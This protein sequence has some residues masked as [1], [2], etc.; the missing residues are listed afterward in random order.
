MDTGRCKLCLQKRPLL[1][2]SHIIPEFMYRDLF[3]EHHKMY[4][5]APSSYVEGDRK[6]MRPSSGEYDSDILCAECDNERLGRLESYAQQ[7]MYGGQLPEQERPMVKNVKTPEGVVFSHATNLSYQKFK[8]FLLSILWRA[9]VSRRDFFK[10]VSLGPYEEIIRNM[11]MEDDPKTEDVFPIIMLTW[12]NDKSTPK[13]LVGQPGKNRAEKGIRY[14]FIIGGITYVFYVSPGWLPDR[15]KPFT[16]QPS[17]EAF[18]L[19]IP[20]GKSWELW[21]TYFNVK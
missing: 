6:V 9:S 18:L 13:D 2:K 12:L 11:L 14:V 3:D 17:N 10:E 1:N 16:L 8:L 21:K 15:L 7:A 4:K 19:H 5:L 20:E